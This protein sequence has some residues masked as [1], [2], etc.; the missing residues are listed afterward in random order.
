[1][2][3]S[4]KRIPCIV[5]LAPWLGFS[6]QCPSFSLCPPA[7]PR[8]PACLSAL[9]P[10]VCCCPLDLAAGKEEKAMPEALAAQS[11]LASQA[12]QDFW[13]CHTPVS[14]PPP[15]FSLFGA[16]VHRNVFGACPVPG[17]V[18]TEV[19][20]LFLLEGGSR[21]RSQGSPRVLPSTAS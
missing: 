6:R 10:W 7:R 19:K 3:V 5:A 9:G 17:A 15:Q 12:L 18:P 14:P 2:S 16:R 11:S 8:L 13:G 1:M 20:L 21:F 4:P